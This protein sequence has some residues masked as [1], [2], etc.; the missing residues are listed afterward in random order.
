MVE[1]DQVF[2]RRFPSPDSRSLKETDHIGVHT[3]QRFRIVN[4]KFTVLIIASKSTLSLG[5]LHSD[6]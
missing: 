3:E 2:Q 6:T 1:A 5:S 4:L